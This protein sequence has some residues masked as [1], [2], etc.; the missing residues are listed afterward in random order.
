MNWL[1]ISDLDMR[2]VLTEALVDY[3]VSLVV[4]LRDRNI[5]YA[6]PWKNFI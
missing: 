2:Q 5:Y 4:V 3:E 1:T 6:I